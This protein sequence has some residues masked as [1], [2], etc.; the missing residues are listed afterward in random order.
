MR[1]TLGVPVFNVSHSAPG[2]TKVLHV[3]SR[4]ERLSAGP[5]PHDGDQH[6]SQQW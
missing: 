3:Q 6:N 1:D 5:R 2:Q 4:G